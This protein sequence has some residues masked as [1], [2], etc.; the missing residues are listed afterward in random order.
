MQACLGNDVRKIELESWYT[1]MGKIW[2]T[3]CNMRWH[4]NSSNL[5]DWP[6][7]DNEVK[8]GQI[9]RVFYQKG[10]VFFYECGYVPQYRLLETPGV[11]AVQQVSA[12][13]IPGQSNLFS[14]P[15]CSEPSTR[16]PCLARE[17]MDRTCSGTLWEID[18]WEQTCGRSIAQEPYLMITWRIVIVKV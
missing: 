6:Q 13:T 14:Q 17:K 4:S 8:V 12:S 16:W 18:F 3:V 9:G 7:Q 11:L 15:P 2:L 1:T 5:T 10:G